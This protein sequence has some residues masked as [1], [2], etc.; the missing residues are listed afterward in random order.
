MNTCPVCSE[1]VAMGRI[2]CAAEGDV[3]PCGGCGRALYVSPRPASGLALEFASILLSWAVLVTS[4]LA[5]GDHVGWTLAGIFTLPFA[6]IAAFRAIARPLAAV[7]PPSAARMAIRPPCTSTLL[8]PQ[9][10]A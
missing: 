8:I 3:I 10:N 6:E 5:W 4:A 2:F 1:A 9:H 7:G